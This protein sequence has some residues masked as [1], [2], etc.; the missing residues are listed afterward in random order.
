MIAS[1]SNP[2]NML[3]P[4]LEREFG[5]KTVKLALD[6]GFTCPNRDGTC[7]YGG[8]SF[9]SERGSGDNAS[10]IDASILQPYSES[11]TQNTTDIKNTKSAINAQIDLLSTKWT[12]VKNYIAY[13]QNY[14]GTYASTERLE[15]IY[16]DALSNEKI[17]GLAIATRPDCLPFETLDSLQ[18]LNEKT[19]L[20]VELGL[21]TTN[22]KTANSFG[23]GYS[24]EIYYQATEELS[25]RGIRFVTHLLFGLPHESYEDMKKSLTDVL[26][27]GFTPWGLKFHLLNIVKGTRLAKEMPDYIPFDS[28]ETYV[29]MVCDFLEI[30]PPEI[31]MHRLSAD[32]PAELLIAPKWAYR[33]RLLLNM[34]N[35]EM[36]RRS[37]YQGCLLSC[38]NQAMPD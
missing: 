38:R 25:K 35:A 36:R 34:I 3:G 28:P 2:I 1:P 14:T 24:T 26:T 15:S 33:K 30:T 37:S 22:D 5:G 20:W 9:C 4:Y 32:S 23:R 10:L 27:V 16:Y 17:N 8:C 13:F 29:S 11:A 12:S 6:G 31:V 7:G 21:Q 19:Y 18:E